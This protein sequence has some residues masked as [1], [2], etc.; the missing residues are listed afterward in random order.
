MEKPAID[1]LHDPTKPE[2]YYFDDTVRERVLA[3]R[4][5]VRAVE[6]VKKAAPAKKVAKA[7]KKAV[8]K[9]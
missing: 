5:K 8:K 2:V 6:P 3:K 1:N 9:R 4:A 7:V